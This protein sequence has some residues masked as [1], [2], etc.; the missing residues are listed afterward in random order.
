MNSLTIEEIIDKWC[1][2]DSSSLNRRG[3]TNET[4]MDQRFLWI[5]KKGFPHHE[6]HPTPD[7]PS[8]LSKSPYDLTIYDKKEFTG[9]QQKFRPKNWFRLSLISPTY[10][11]S[12]KLSSFRMLFISIEPNKLNKIGYIWIPD[13]TF[14]KGIFFIKGTAVF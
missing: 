6:L 10:M 1:M 14:L 9:Y 7:K 5:T 3:F 13:K 8:S 12:T 4:S 2:I 11:S